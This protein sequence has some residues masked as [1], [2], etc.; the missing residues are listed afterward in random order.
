MHQCITMEYRLPIF[1]RQ[2]CTAFSIGALI[3]PG[4]IDNNVSPS[5][6]P[7]SSIYQRNRHYIIDKI[8][9]LTLSNSHQR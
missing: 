8:L 1:G 7:S 9:N 3:S 5:I 6:T 4:T 2:V